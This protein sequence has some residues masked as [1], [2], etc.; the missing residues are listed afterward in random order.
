[1][2][3]M[4]KIANSCFREIPDHFENIELDEYFVMPNRVHG[5]IGIKHNESRDA[6]NRVSTAGGKTKQ[7]NLM[8]S[9]SSLSKVIRWFKGQCT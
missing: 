4:G 8:L 5:I 2:N 9:K 6:I 3:E 1:M 7:K